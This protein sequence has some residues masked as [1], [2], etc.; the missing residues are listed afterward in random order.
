MRFLRVWPSDAITLTKNK[1]LPFSS[2]RAAIEREALFSTLARGA[3][4][5]GI[6]AISE[7]FKGLAVVT[8]GDMATADSL[9][10]FIDVAGQTLRSLTGVGR[11]VW[12]PAK[13]RYLLI[14]SVQMRSSRTGSLR[15]LPPQGEV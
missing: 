15:D 2:P 8:T 11:F 5:H 12:V 6:F 14:A 3:R 10:E 7:I 4:L 13:A 1:G 9:G